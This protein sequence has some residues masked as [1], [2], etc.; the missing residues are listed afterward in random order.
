MV[1]LRIRKLRPAP[2]LSLQTLLPSTDIQGRVAIRLLYIGLILNFNDTKK[3]KKKTVDFVTWFSLG[4]LNKYYYR[5]IILLVQGFSSK[6]CGDRGESYW[7]LAFPL[8]VEI[9]WESQSSLWVPHAD[10][11]ERP[12]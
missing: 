6:R 3:K 9:L 12:A 1:P 10:S 7:I 4:V 2:G 8:L 5:N 11:F